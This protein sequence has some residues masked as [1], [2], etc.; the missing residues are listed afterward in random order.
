[1]NTFFLGQI[2]GGMLPIYLLSLILE[3]IFYK[4]NEKIEKII[5]STTLSLLL[6]SAIANIGYSDGEE[7]QF[8]SVFIPY[9]IS[10]LLLLLSR[11][12]FIKK[13]NNFPTKINFQS[14]HSLILSIIIYFA[15][16]Y[17]VSLYYNSAKIQLDILMHKGWNDSKKELRSTFEKELE[18]SL[19]EEIKNIPSDIKE[20]YLNCLT[21]KSVQYLNQ[22]NCKYKYNKK[23]TTLEEHLKEQSE[24]Y[25]SSG[26]IAYFEKVINNCSEYA[27]Q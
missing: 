10:G 13:T 6:T 21:E 8:L 5:R 1:M 4:K 24:C 27:F 22:T 19:G 15:L 9:T 11:I 3:Y 18:F 7:P 23:T 25:E 16:Y 14:Y 26:Y 2:I 20:K 12:V 17:I